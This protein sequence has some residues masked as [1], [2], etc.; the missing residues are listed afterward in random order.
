MFN[1]FDYS[2]NVA[3]SAKYRCGIKH[4]I[5]ILTIVNICQEYQGGVVTTSPE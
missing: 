3:I 2:F 4:V 5:V 1:M